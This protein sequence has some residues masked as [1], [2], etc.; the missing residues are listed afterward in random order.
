MNN[1][2]LSI[3][4][5][6][7]NE[8]DMKVLGVNTI[9]N[10][11][12]FRLMSSK[13]VCELCNYEERNIYLRGLVPLLGYRTGQVYYERLSRKA[14]KSKYSLVKMVNFAIDGITSFSVKPVQLYHI[15]RELLPSINR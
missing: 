9:Y 12:D 13:A 3:V 5:P 6:C 14:G 10:H 11:A 1:N 8:E 7:Y 4:I 15:E 2:I